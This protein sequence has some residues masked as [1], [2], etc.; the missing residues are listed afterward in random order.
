MQYRDERLSTGNVVKPI[1]LFDHVNRAAGLIA[2]QLR[3][4]ERF[5]DQALA[6]ECGIAVDQNRQNQVAVTR[7]RLALLGTHS[8]FHDRVDSL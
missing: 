5:G 3:Q 4:V 7:G 6:G 2:T 8:A 1:W